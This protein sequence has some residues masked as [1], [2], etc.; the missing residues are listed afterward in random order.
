M[1][2][3]EMAWLVG[4]GLVAG[5]LGGLL[6]IGGST[7]MIPAMVVLLKEE[8]HLAAAAAMIVN[9]A[10]AIPSVT[11]HQRA[12]AVHWPLVGRLAGFG[13]VMIIVGVFCSNLMPEQAL[14]SVFGVFLLYV[15]ATNTQKLIANAPE[16]ELHHERTG[17][18]PAGVVGSITGFAAGVLGI[19]GGAICVPLLQ[20]VCQLPLRRCIA[21]SAALMCITAGFGAFVKN[22]S[23]ADLPGDLSWQ[24][25]LLLAGLLTPTAIIGGLVGATLTHVAPIKVIRLAFILL[26]GFASLKMFGVV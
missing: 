1:T 18:L 6:G 25:S 12:G 3:D 17:W 2:P 7:V 23:L 5:V 21:A 14:R 20:K 13:I 8:Q 22:W 11:R 4:I 24:R 16:P 19:G 10:I 26:M 15:V 9:A